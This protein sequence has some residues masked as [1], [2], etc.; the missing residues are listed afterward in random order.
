LRDVLELRRGRRPFVAAPLRT[1]VDHRTRR[2]I[3]FVCRNPLGFTLRYGASNGPARD[4]RAGVSYGA[5]CVGCCWALMGLLIAFGVMNLVVMLIV[6]ATVLGE[7]VWSHGVG[8][9][10]A[11][12]IAAFAL[13]VLVVVRPS[14]AGGL[15]THGGEM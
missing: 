9:S 5:F 8:L 13:A 15:H 1:F 10:L 6:A 7:R 12:G 3:E 14:L 4:L 2:T 11:F